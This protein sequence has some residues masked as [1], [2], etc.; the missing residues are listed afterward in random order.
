MVPPWLKYPDLPRLSLGWRMGRGEE[1][2]NTVYR[3][4]S[5]LSPEEQDD[6]QRR[7]PEPTDWHGWY[8]MVRANPWITRDDGAT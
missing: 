5:R 2:Y 7:F 6:Y 1:H 3:Q 4:F 8:D